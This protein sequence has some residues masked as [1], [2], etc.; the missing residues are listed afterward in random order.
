MQEPFCAVCETIEAATASSRRRQAK[1]RNNFHSALAEGVEQVSNT[2]QY[3]GLG[4]R[5]TVDGGCSLFANL[6]AK[7]S[8]PTGGIFVAKAVEF[9]LWFFLGHSFACFVWQLSSGTKAQ[10]ERPV[11]GLMFSSPSRFFRGFVGRI[12]SFGLPIHLQAKS[13]VVRQLASRD[14][15][16]DGFLRCRWHGDGPGL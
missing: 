13:V 16:R 15:L 8:G 14:R 5:H 2:L 11:S 10:P 6:H 12:R 7:A 9:R 3:G 4:F 1:W